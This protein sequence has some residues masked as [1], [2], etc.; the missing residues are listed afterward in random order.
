MRINGGMNLNIQ[1]SKKLAKP[2]K[3]TN[4]SIDTE[5]LKEAKEL[6]INLSSSAEDGLREAVRQTKTE[7]WNLENAEA[8]KS[9]NKWV[10]KN[11]IPLEEYR[12][13]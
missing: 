2:K 12:Q 1:S 6:G 11:D 13:F 5:L 10:E 8:I 9:W 3:P 7:Q 4:L